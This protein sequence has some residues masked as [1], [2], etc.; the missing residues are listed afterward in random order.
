MEESR[1]ETDP[2]EMRRIEKEE[3]FD[4]QMMDQPI[5]FFSK[6][7]L[8]PGYI[9]GSALNTSKEE[10]HRL[11]LIGS[12]IIFETSRLALYGAIPYFLYKAYEMSR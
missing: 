7:C 12:A 9:L 5:R 3:E 4:R 2:R 6:L 8:I 11:E 1:N 10:D